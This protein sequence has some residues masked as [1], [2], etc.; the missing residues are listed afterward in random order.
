MHRIRRLRG[1]GSLLVA[2]IG[3][4]IVPVSTD[5]RRGFGSP[6]GATR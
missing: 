5:G 6:I 4:E 2:G 1:G 3:A